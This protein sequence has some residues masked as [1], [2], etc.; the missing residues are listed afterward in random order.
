MYIGYNVQLYIG[1]TSTL[2]W[3]LRFTDLLPE[4]MMGIV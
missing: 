2:W 3:K 4:P 1:M